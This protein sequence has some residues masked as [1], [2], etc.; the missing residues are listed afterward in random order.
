MSKMAQEK[1]SNTHEH[2]EETVTTDS[3][4][5]TD[6]NMGPVSTEVEESGLDVDNANMAAPGSPDSVDYRAL[7]E[8][9]QVRA[10]ELDEDI[11]N[12][13]NEIPALRAAREER[14]D[15]M[16]KIYALIHADP[17]ELQRVAV[18]HDTE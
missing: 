8:S 18:R 3:S 10:K 6:A 15:A 16:K 5:Q 13:L 12:K 14:K 17:E 11:L 4:D 7:V 2:V 9:Q 1:S